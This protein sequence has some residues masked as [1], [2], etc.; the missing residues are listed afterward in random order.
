MV[1]MDMKNLVLEKHQPD[2]EHHKPKLSPF[3]RLFR[4]VGWW[5]GF[6][7]LYATFSACP[8]CGQQGCPGG[9][10]SSSIVGAFFALCLQDWKRLY[11]FL[12]RKLSRKK[13]LANN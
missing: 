13:A 2:H 12:K 3:G 4:F 9:I 11:G 8:I 1:F 6:T 5:F 7:G 10:L